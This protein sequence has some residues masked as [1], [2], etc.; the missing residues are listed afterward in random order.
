V[1]TAYREEVYEVWVGFAFVGKEEVEDGRTGQGSA[2]TSASTP[3]IRGA[4]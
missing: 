1:W 2:S 4:S 3:A